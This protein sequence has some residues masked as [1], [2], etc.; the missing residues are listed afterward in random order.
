MNPTNKKSK[1]EDLP[2]SG[3]KF[4]DG[5]VHTNLIPHS[6][7]SEKGHNFILI[8]GMTAECTECHWGFELD[9]GDIIKEGHLYNKKGKFII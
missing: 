3:S 7:L 5:E 1:L 6:E 9:R 8:K 2:E 4:W